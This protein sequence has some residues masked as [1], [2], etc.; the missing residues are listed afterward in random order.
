MG[1]GIAPSPRPDIDP[2]ELKKRKLRHAYCLRNGLQEQP[3]DQAFLFGGDLVTKFNPDQPRSY[4]GR[5]AGTG[6]GETANNAK[7]HEKAG[8]AHMEAAAHPARFFVHPD[9]K[10][11]HARAAG[12]HKEAM[13]AHF[14][15]GSNTGSKYT[16]DD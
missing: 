9:E 13:Y 2:E 5:F 15:L 14:A 11:A 4:D 16:A 6:A 1:N 8:K 10:A 3:A 12:L 7:M